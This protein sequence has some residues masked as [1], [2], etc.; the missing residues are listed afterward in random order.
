MLS[1]GTK[2]GLKSEALR[3]TFHG[4]RLSLRLRTRDAQ[5]SG[6]DVGLDEVDRLLN[7]A[8]VFLLFV[9]DLNLKGIFKSHHQF[10]RVEAVSAEVFDEGS[11]VLDVGFVLAK[12]FSDDLLDLLFLFV[13]LM[14]VV[15]YFCFL[16]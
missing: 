15:R 4:S 10:D 14:S 7:S 13:D 11:L 9:G 5:T 2:K 1:A 8:Q 12:L 6:L 16:L 3:R